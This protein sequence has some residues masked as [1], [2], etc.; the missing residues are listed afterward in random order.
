[1]NL[2]LKWLE[3]SENEWTGASHWVIN[4]EHLLGGGDGK[5]K[6]TLYKKLV[7]TVLMP[8]K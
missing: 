4:N 6:P 5:G 8:I 2:Y 3:S 1:M 7:S